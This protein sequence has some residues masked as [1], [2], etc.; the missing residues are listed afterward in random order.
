MAWKKKTG[1]WFQGPDKIF[2]LGASLS[3]KEKRGPKPG[4]PFVYDGTRTGTG[5]FRFA[6]HGS[7]VITAVRG[8]AVVKNGRPATFARG[9]D[10][11][12]DPGKE[13]LGLQRLLARKGKQ[14]LRE[15]CMRRADAG[16]ISRLNDCA[17]LLHR[18]KL[19]AYVFDAVEHS[20]IASR[21]EPSRQ[22]TLFRHIRIPVDHFQ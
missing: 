8:R 5:S 11:G 10:D 1:F 13:W 15:V 21:M 3:S 4:R 20:E 14:S 12:A 7:T 22:L 17:G 2:R 18:Q 19:D 16:R 9:W 6:E